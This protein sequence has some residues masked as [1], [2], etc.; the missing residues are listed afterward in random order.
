MSETLLNLLETASIKFTNREFEQSS[1]LYKKALFELLIENHKLYM[2]TQDLEGAEISAK[3]LLTLD[4]NLF[5]GYQRY[6]Q[7]L[8]VMSK[9]NIAEQ[10]IAKA[11]ENAI[12]INE[13]KNIVDIAFDKILIELSKATENSS[14]FDNALSLLDDLNSKSGL[15]PEIKE[16]ISFSKIEIYIKQENYH[17]ALDLLSKFTPVNGDDERP[18]YLKLTCYAGLDDYD[19]TIKYATKVEKGKTDFFIYFAKY[20]KA[21]VSYK[22]SR[23]GLIFPSLAE[24]FYSEAVMFLKEVCRK[25]NDVFAYM[26]L[27]RLYIE[28]NKQAIAKELINKLPLELQIELDKYFASYN[29]EG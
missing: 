27:I 28:N 19:N 9:F 4:R 7:I 21:F 8:I 29:F 17:E 20:S 12:D 24:N 23:H 1:N 26:F 25:T 2:A 18:N 6:F 16:A 22:L 11:E 10:V 14:H 3:Q 15:S 5:E 13:L